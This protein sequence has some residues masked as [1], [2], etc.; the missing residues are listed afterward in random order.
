[1]KA[2]PARA[3]HTPIG[4]L[5]SVVGGIGAWTVHLLYLSSFAGFGCKHPEW[6]WSM[7][8]LTAATAGA[9]ALAIALAWALFRS[10][11]DD[12]RSG[13]LGGQ[14]RF[15]GV[16]GLLVGGINLVLILLE[17]SYAIF[18]SPCA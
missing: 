18:I 1:M 17:G 12:E 2:I 13:T 16:L 9:T 5:Y 14:L 4:M 8:A 15:L 10:A 11:G 6:R 7:H 3:A